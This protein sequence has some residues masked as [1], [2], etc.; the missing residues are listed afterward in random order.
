[1][2]ETNVVNIQDLIRSGK[3]KIA[4]GA[5]QIKA[6]EGQKTAL[7]LIEAGKLNTMAVELLPEVLRPYARVEN[8]N[9]L[10]VSAPDCED[11]VRNLRVKISTI[12]PDDMDGWTYDEVQSV[13]FA[14][15]W[16]V[17]TWGVWQDDGGHWETYRKL[18]DEDTDDIERALAYASEMATRLEIAQIEADERNAKQ[19]VPETKETKPAAHP[20][21]PL[22]MM[23]GLEFDECIKE[24]CAWFIQFRGENTCAVKTI[25]NAALNTLPSED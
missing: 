8:D 20:L 23:G 24:G 6:R 19:H 17:T 14:K 10:V 7:L 16:R 22:R 3:D 18:T 25:G 11:I 4:A 9:V 21:C 5:A 1:M 12:W 15:G 2:A 13:D